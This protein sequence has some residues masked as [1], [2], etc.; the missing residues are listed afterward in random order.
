M[1]SIRDGTPIYLAATIT[2]RGVGG[3]KG[4]SAGAVTAAYGSG[5]ST[6]F[7]HMAMISRWVDNRYTKREYFA[8]PSIPLYLTTVLW[9]PNEHDHWNAFLPANIKKCFPHEPTP[10]GFLLHHHEDDPLSFWEVPDEGG[11]RRLTALTPDLIRPFSGAADLFNHVERE[12]LGKINV[13]FPP[14]NYVLS[15]RFL[16]KVKAMAALNRARRGEDRGRSRA[17]VTQQYDADPE[18]AE[19][20]RGRGRPRERVMVP[21]EEIEVEP[22]VFYHEFIDHMLREKG[23]EHFALFYDDV[24]HFLQAYQTDLNFHL[25]SIFAGQSFPAMRKSNTSFYAA[26]HD[27]SLLDWKVLLRFRT[28]FWLPTAR[29]IR[30]VSRVWQ[31]VVDSLPMGRAIIEDR[32]LG[33]GG[34]PYSRIPR[35]P[36]VVLTK[37]LSL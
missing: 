3:G 30:K 27:L 22:H 13:I 21:L 35:Q 31:S 14:Q 5:K 32:E 29:V 26:T 16:K 25:I 4:G 7:Q 17:R 2:D 34:I 19:Y 12:G 24:S 23:S 28:F 11:Q 36:P 18:M 9:F 20:H 10:K 6:L 37:G 1:S 15:Q 8:D 33:F